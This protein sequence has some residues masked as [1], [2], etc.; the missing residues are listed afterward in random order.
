MGNKHL[1]NIWW[2]VLVWLAISSTTATARDHSSRDRNKNS[3]FSLITQ[4]QYLGASLSALRQLLISD[5]SPSP[6]L[7]QQTLIEFASDIRS[8]NTEERLFTQASSIAERM[9][10]V[11]AL[12]EVIR[13]SCTPIPGTIPL[14]QGAQVAESIE[15]S[16][17]T[18]SANPCGVL[19]VSD[20]DHLTLTL[21]TLTPHGYKFAAEVRNS[22]VLVPLSVNGDPI[23]DVLIHL[24][25]R[26]V[27][28]VRADVQSTPV[29]LDCGIDDL[30]SLDGCNYWAGYISNAASGDFPAQFTLARGY[31]AI[32]VLH[33]NDVWRIFNTHLEVAGFPSSDAAIQNLQAG[34]LLLQAVPDDTNRIAPTAAPDAIIITGD[35]NS[36]PDSL[37]SL[38]KGED[39]ATAFITDFIAASPYAQLDAS[40]F[41]DAW[42]LRSGRPPG[43]TCCQD[44]NLLNAESQLDRRIDHVFVYPEPS[45]VK[46]NLIGDDPID[47]TATGLL[48]PSDH[49][50]VWVRFAT[51][52]KRGKKPAKQ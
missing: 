46:A 19:P 37:V 22:E 5:S 36:S 8:T 15:A 35:F 20:I 17:I 48:W 14:I 40:I 7:V 13:L 42:L 26:D 6:A 45:R 33:N 2:L 34:E 28:L 41:T 39:S 44:A 16:F 27:L 18:D 23:P 11:V 9:P 52:N 4:N 12:Q 25:D 38:A 51:D 49:A 30:G 43:Y 10:H 31:V 29:E 50:G 47:K 21:D 1:V 24:E 3:E 32:D